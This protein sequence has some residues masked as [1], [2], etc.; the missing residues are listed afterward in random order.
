M[1]FSKFYSYFYCFQKNC[2]YM[3]DILLDFIM[4]AH[5]GKVRS[6]NMLAEI[7]KLI[8]SILTLSNPV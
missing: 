5:E 6:Y 3:T 2:M 1:N 7:T 8:L 4:Y